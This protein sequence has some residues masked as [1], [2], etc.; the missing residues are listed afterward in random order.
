[1]IPTHAWKLGVEIL[2]GPV[3]KL[4]EIWSPQTLVGVS[5]YDSQRALFVTKRRKSYHHEP[6]SDGIA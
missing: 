1:M 5:E 4:I 6:E 3:T 2:A